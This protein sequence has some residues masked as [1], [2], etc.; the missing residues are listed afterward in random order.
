MNVSSFASPNGGLQGSLA[1]WPPP[2]PR[3]QGWELRSVPETNWRQCDGRECCWYLPSTSKTAS[4]SSGCQKAPRPQGKVG[5]SWP[6]S[7]LWSSPQLHKGK[8]RSVRSCSSPAQL[9]VNNH[10]SRGHSLA[11]AQNFVP[12]RTCTQ[13]QLCPWE[14][15]NKLKCNR[16]HFYFL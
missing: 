6:H 5:T 14:Q 16:S 1:S 11:E 9:V 15:G 13:C 2:P 12:C 3:G 10:K 7:L 8:I 4:G